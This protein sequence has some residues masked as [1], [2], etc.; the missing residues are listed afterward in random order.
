MKHLIQR[1]LLQLYGI[2]ERS[3]MLD[4]RPGRWLFERSYTAYKALVEAKEVKLL[5]P[6]VTPGQHVLDIGANIGFFTLHFG[7]W[8]S[9][10]GK[11][12][13]AEPEPGN[14]HRLVHYVQK[15][16]LASRIVPV[17]AAVAEKAGE[18][19]LALNDA[20]PADHRLSTNGIP[21]QALTVDSLVEDYCSQEGVCLI[22][23]DVQGAETRVLKGASHT[24]THWRPAIYIELDNE[25]LAQAGTSSDEVLT[26]LS[27]HG[28]RAIQPR[29]RGRPV[30]LDGEEIKREIRQKGYADFLFVHRLNEKG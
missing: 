30:A 6:Y 19:R 7:R 21:V 17:N 3:G 18:L 25:C 11:V 26:I 12:V 14:F 22:K 1:G 16:H 8:V 24:L 5:R 15:N 9:G 4:T 20:N 28:Y 27:E 29:K 10:S 13:A 2:T 23:I